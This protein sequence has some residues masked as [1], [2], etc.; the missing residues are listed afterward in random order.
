M[1]REELVDKFTD[2]FRFTVEES[3]KIDSNSI[4]ISLAEFGGQAFIF[5]YYNDHSFKLETK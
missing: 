1:H 3:K 4:E 2:I 5:T